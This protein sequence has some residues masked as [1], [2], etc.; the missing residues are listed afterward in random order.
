MVTNYEDEETQYFYCD[1]SGFS[2]NEMYGPKE[3]NLV[4]C[5]ITARP[6][7][8]TNFF[9][10]IKQYKAGSFEGAELINKMESDAIIRN[11]IKQILENYKDKIKISCDIFKY[12]ELKQK[13]KNKKRLSFHDHPIENGKMGF[14]V[15]AYCHIFWSII[16]QN[17]KNKNDKIELFL[18]QVDPRVK[19]SLEYHTKNQIGARVSIKMRGEENLP[20]YGENGVFSADFFAALMRKNIEE[21]C[22][23]DIISILQIIVY[24]QNIFLDKDNNYIQNIENLSTGI[25]T[26]SSITAYNSFTNPKNN[27]F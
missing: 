25:I 26:S 27:R 16:E 18:D 13:I 6:N 19:Q 10:E 7:I 3:E 23:N 22:F 2:K 17:F 11:Q 5:Y 1:E 8:I 9:E 12:A 14:L 4:I 15:R 20:N 21:N 24:K